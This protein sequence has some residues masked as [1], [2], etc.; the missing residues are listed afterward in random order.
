MQH[1]PIDDVLPELL[2]VLDEYGVAVLQAPPGAGKSTRVPPAILDSKMVQG[3]ILMLEP[4][5]VAARAVATRIAAER[6]QRVGEEIGYAVRFDRKVSARTCVEIV[7]EGL[8]LRRLQHDPLLEDVGCVILDEFHER[9]VNADLALAMLREVREVREDLKLVVM[10]ATLQMEP[11]QRYLDAPAVTSQ[12]RT[13][14]VQITHARAGGNLSADIIEQ[15]KLFA[16]DPDEQDALIFLSGARQIR[17]VLGAIAPI[18]SSHAL[19]LFPLYGALSLDEQLEA[20]TS[21]PQRRRVIAATNIA[22][23]S[24]TV[25]GV[26]TVIDAGLVKQ[27]R[28]DPVSG[29][30]RLEEIKIARDSAAQ[31]AGRAGRVRP[32]RAV[33]LWSTVDHDLRA[34][35]TSPEIERVDVLPV[36]LDVIAWSSSDPAEFAWFEAPPTRALVAGVET[37]RRLRLISE[38]GFTLTPRGEH[39]RGLPVHPRLGCMMLEGARQGVLEEVVGAVALLSEGERP[40]Q[41]GRAPGACDLWRHVKQFDKARRRDNRAKRITQ[42]RRQLMQQMSTIKRGKPN[43]S[44]PEDRFALCVLAGYPDRVC[45]WREGSE[46]DDYVMVGGVPLTLTRESCVKG[47]TWIVATQIAGTRRI[48]TFEST[49]G[50]KERGL[51]RVATHIERAW[52]E[53]LY[54][55]RFTEDVEIRF[56]EEL[57]RLSARRVKRFDEL[58]LSS[59]TASIKHHADKAS[60]AEALARRVSEDLVRSFAPDKEAEQLLYRVVMLVTHRPDLEFPDLRDM[61]WED[62]DAQTAEAL[63]RW[64]WGKRGF[65]DLRRK[66][67][68]ACIKETLTYAQS[69]TL[70]ELVPA[71]IKVPSGSQMRVDYEDAQSSPVLAVRIQEVFGWTQTPRI[72]GGRVELVLHLLA[73]NYRPAQVTQ[74]LASFWENIYPDV[75]KELRAR[76]PKHA[77]PEDPWTA[78]AVKKGSSVKRQQG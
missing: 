33:R 9:S 62:R 2:A 24:L 26:T 67:L 28:S 37:L 64:C 60:L 39:V 8:L 7:T 69:Q 29:L 20:I 65:A 6:G 78:K 72:L 31:R 4:R 50:V 15:V 35:A 10:S 42:V 49:S 38:Q 22:E 13:F 27:M 44:S 23:T 66:G 40:E 75:R 17:E 76:Y 73:P 34:E 45:M 77:W 1:L 48:S 46:R 14:P 47:S 41:G 71:R 58:M 25:N 63:N 59:E 74:D 16:Q 70:D 55:E 5:R 19:D 57:E 52:L 56:D 51:I 61:P 18:A 43:A 68:V 21:K 36:L 11:L 54:P 30:D 32:G 12:G 53:E 3:K